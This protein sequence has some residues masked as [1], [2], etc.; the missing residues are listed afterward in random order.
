MYADA[1]GILYRPSSVFTH[2]KWIQA[3]FWILL[4]FPNSA[5]A[6]SG[7]HLSPAFSYL[8]KINSLPRAWL[9]NYEL[10]SIEMHSSTPRSAYEKVCQ[11]AQ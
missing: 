11:A 1:K 2:V 4:Y 5:I 3:R 8:Q 10:Q 9:K 7:C 6:S